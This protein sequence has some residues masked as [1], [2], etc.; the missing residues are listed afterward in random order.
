MIIALSS[1]AAY[2]LLILQSRYVNGLQY[3]IGISSSTCMRK[4]PVRKCDFSR[5]R[6]VLFTDSCLSVYV[7]VTTCNIETTEE[8]KIRER[9]RYTVDEE[10]ELLPNHDQQTIFAFG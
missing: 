7:N 3:S 1:F 2:L 9:L 6:I 10:E 4:Q 5:T 8:I